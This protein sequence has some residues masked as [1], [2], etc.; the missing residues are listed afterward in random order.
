MAL[1]PCL[2]G[3]VLLARIIECSFER[4]DMVFKSRQDIRFGQGFELSI[5]LN[6]LI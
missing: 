2:D 3:F 6:R 1:P 4:L 5:T